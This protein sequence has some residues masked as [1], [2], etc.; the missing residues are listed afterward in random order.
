MTEVPLSRII[1]V[2][3]LT[4]PS[5]LANFNV[6]SIGL[7]T[8]EAPSPAFAD[9]FKIYYSPDGVAT[10]FGSTSETYD[11]AVAIFSQSPN[12]LTGGGYLVIFP[13]EILGAD[14]AGTM[15]TLAPGTLADFKAVTSGGFDISIDSAAQNILTLDFSGAADFD[16]VA[17]IIQAAL[18]SAVV[19]TLCVYDATAN[20]SEGGFLI[21][22]PTTG[23]ASKISKLTSPATGTDISGVDYM[24]GAGNVRIIDGQAT[25]VTED[26]VTAIIRTKALQYYFGILATTEPSVT[27]SFNLATYVQTQDMLLFLPRDNTAEILTIFKLIQEATL[28]HTRCL[29]YTTGAEEARKM[30]GAYDSRLFGINFTGSNTMATMNLKTLAGI[31]PDTGAVSE[32]INTKAKLYGFDIY[33]SIAGDSAVLSYGANSYSD[34]IYGQLWFKLGIQVA[35]FNYLKTTNTKIPQTEP[36][37]DGLKG[38]YAN[39]CEQGITNGYIAAGLEWTSPTTFGNPDDLRRNIRDKGYY[40]YSQ[41]IAQQSVADRAARKA[42][43]VQIAIKQAGAIHKSDVIV[44]VN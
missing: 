42:P 2:S 9:D 15:L 44:Q 28:T 26:L 21:T 41:P 5:G 36:G 11:Q 8:D 27:D 35:G 40:I 18:N 23:V 7:L 4:T 24:N 13:L 12:I 17:T 25:G 19:G 37:M 30:G 29:L 6:N 43:L 39:V 33:V 1:N 34:E 31:T 10:D 16:A 22:S 20:D 32:D 14:S 38:S 3:L